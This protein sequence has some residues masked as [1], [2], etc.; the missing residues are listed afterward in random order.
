MIQASNNLISYFFIRGSSD[1]CTFL[2]FFFNGLIPSLIGITCWIICVSYIP[3]PS[4]AHTNKS[5]YCL[6]KQTKTCHSYGMQHILRL[7]NFILWY[8]HRLIYSFI[9]VELWVFLFLY[10]E[11]DYACHRS[12]WEKPHPLGWGCLS[13]HQLYFARIACAHLHKPLCPWRHQR[14]HQSSVSIDH[15]QKCLN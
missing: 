7:T 15:C 2:I 4:Y 1:G 10:L 5:L 14:C 6:K 8:V 3:R 9:M 13:C 11:S 12:F